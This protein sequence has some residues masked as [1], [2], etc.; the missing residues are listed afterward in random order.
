MPSPDASEGGEAS[1][2]RLAQPAPG[3]LF[4]G[5]YRVERL[6]GRGAMGAVWAVMDQEVGDRVALKLLTDPGQHGDL[7]EAT[8]RFRREVRLARRVTHRN[9]ARI[10]D[11]GTH[12]GLLYLTMELVDG[13]SL[14]QILQCE[15]PLAP[16]RAAEIGRQIALGLDAAHQVDVVHRD[17]K[18]GNVLIESGGRVVLTDFGLARATAGDPK[19]TRGQLFAGTPSYMAPEQVRGEVVGPATDLYALGVVLFEMLTGRCPFVRDTAVATA[20]ARLE[21]APPDPAGLAQISAPLSK[22]VLGCLERAPESRPAEARAVATALAPFARA[23]TGVPASAPTSADSAKTLLGPAPG[24]AAT[25]ASRSHGKAAHERTLAVLPFRTRGAEDPSGFAEAITEELVDTLALTKS[26]RVTAARATARYRGA[27][28]DPRE[29]GA[30]LGVHALVDGT[31]QVMGDRVR[32]TVRLLD[33]ASG[34]QLWVGRFDGSLADGFELQTALAQRITEGLR[35]ELEL[36]SGSENVAEEAVRLYV[37]AKRHTEVPDFLGENLDAALDLLDRCLELE[38][39]FEL[40]IAA[41]ADA[42]VR[43]WVSPLGQSHGVIADRAHESVERALDKAPHLPLT[44]YAAGRLAVSDGAF[45]VAAR[46]LTTAVSMAPTFAAVHEYL[47]ALQC[48]AGRGDEGERHLEQA[49]RID[50]NQAGGSYAVARR[51]AL[52]RDLDR[53]DRLIAELKTRPQV[54]RFMLESLEMRVGGW[55]GDKERV[56]RN[57]PAVFIPAD[58]PVARFMDV[59]RASLLGE[60][61]IEEMADCLASVLARHPGPRLE[62]FARQ[63]AIEVFVPQG[64]DQH[65]LEQLDL[66]A[67]SP[68][69]VD[70]E[71]LELC[72]ALDPLRERHDLT[73]FVASVR[74]R[75]DAIW[76]AR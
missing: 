40:A 29:A 60:Q 76:R 68:V 5:R 11:L 3:E 52:N 10:F 13:E 9:A 22:L 71:W 35:V 44:R 7:E 6:I 47:G 30:E 18:P 23:A 33:A 31:V 27:T 49:W 28:I 67:G 16:E 36:L 70:A 42:S 62:A 50:P 74:R 4:A 48:E 66:A 19:L 15:A 51:H 65:A 58:H 55:F 17:L 21:E 56:R 24:G 75:A 34:G 1:A 25:T 32:V 57:D 14:E 53:F 20:M 41:H 8:E 46:E 38:P 26:L 54:S 59:M 45:D 2:S 69:F 61:D 64:A 12:R 37:Q 43:R 39:G 63:L 73:R 72:P